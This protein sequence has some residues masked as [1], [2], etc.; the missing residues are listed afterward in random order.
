MPRLAR[1]TL[2]WTALT[3]LWA[4][5]GFAAGLA[6][7]FTVPS[8]FGFKPLTVLSGSMEP[9]LSTGGMVVDEVI[10]PLEA[11]PG[12]VVTFND[13]EDHGRLIT[14][15]LRSIRVEGAKAY[16]VTRGDANDSSERWNVALDAEIGRVVYHVPI[17]GYVRSWI[18]GSSIRLGLLALVGC[19]GVWMLVDIWR[20]RRDPDVERSQQPSR[21]A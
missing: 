9:T 7:A 20:P 14:H 18:S 4:A 16:V 6:A 11:R 5:L 17:L 12:D 1:R 15:R 10:T 13:P 8:L 3:L 19:L 21:A 2:G